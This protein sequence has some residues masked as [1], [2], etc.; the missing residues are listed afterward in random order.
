MLHH[1]LERNPTNR[2]NHVNLFFSPIT[3]ELRK[4]G[5]IRLLSQPH[6]S[7]LLDYFCH[8]VNFICIINPSVDLLHYS[9]LSGDV[10]QLL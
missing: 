5:Q 7:Q 3:S 1:V 10:S 8:V 6:Y 2:L 9:P 4:T